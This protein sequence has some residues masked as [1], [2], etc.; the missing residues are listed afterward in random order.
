[1][2]EDNKKGGGNVTAKS[3]TDKVEAKLLKGARE[4]LEG[5]AQAIIKERNAAQDI[6]NQKE[7]ELTELFSENEDLLDD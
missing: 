3:V 2:G 6:V 1:M 5:K 7:A 4:G